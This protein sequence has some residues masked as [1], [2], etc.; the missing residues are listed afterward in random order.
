M[1]ITEQEKIRI[2]I[3]ALYKAKIDI[4]EIVYRLAINR[5][6]VYRVIA[7]Y[8]QNNTTLRCKGS[9]RRHSLDTS[10]ITLLTTKIA[11]NNRLSREK[12]A[13]SL[14]MEHKKKVS[15]W[16]VGRSL[17]AEGLFSRSLT[18]KPMLTKKNI[19]DRLNAVLEWKNW[20]IKMFRNVIYSD[21]CRFSLKGSDGSI[22][23]RRR[24][25]DK[26]KPENISGTKK[27]GGGSKMLWGCIGYGGVGK[28]ILVEETMDSIRYVRV[29][30]ENLF[31][32]ANDLGLSNT[33]CF[34]QDNAPCHTAKNTLEFFE[35]NNIK[36]LKWPAQ[37]PDLNPIENL[38]SY[39]K[40]KLVAYEF[41]TKVEFL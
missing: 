1:T 9:G 40:K 4:K 25:G 41:K 16:T 26:Y 28:L 37:S 35:R 17:K 23:V 34:Q 12:L 36:V 2:E 11:E 33:F 10:D 32:S 31:E 19:L 24:N 22:K 6:T 7:K 18:I 21:E 38:W 20:P 14:E 27:F 8:K 3:I 5:S 15:K 29:L 13:K 30:S 39:I